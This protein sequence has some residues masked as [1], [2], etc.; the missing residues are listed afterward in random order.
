MSGRGVDMIEELQL[1]RW[2]RLNHQRL[3]AWDDSLHPIILEE[4][5]VIQHEHAVVESVDSLATTSV[6]VG[7][8]PP[9]S[10]GRRIDEEHGSIPVPNPGIALES[11][12]RNT[13]YI[14][15]G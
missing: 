15:H 6:P 7:Y 12:F 10:T 5:R 2:A 9:A 11:P 1:R 8:V 14:V 13:Q 3:T 4:L